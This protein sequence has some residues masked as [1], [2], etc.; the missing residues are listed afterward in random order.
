MGALRG[1]GGVYGGVGVAGIDWG[2]APLPLAG[3][4][5]WRRQNRSGGAILG[6]KAMRATLEWLA[7]HL[8]AGAI[9][10]SRLA[11]RAGCY[12]GQLDAATL[13]PIHNPHPH[14]ICP[15]DFHIFTNA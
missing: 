5:P 12:A 3:F 2:V 11:A 10:R 8:V 4:E 9:I 14:A 15:D 6:E 13:D 7:R 1:F